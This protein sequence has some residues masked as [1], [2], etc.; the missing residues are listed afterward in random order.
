MRKA[1]NIS[2]E[3]QA[4]YNIMDS[5]NTVYNKTVDDKA[6]QIPSKGAEVLNVRNYPRYIIMI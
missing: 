6:E 1:Q 2:Q 5:I 3:L 4:A